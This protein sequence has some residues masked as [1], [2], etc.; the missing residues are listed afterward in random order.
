[1]EPSDQRICQEQLRELVHKSKI[2]NCGDLVGLSI[3]ADVLTNKMPELNYIFDTVNPSFAFVSEILPKNRKRIY[4]HEEFE[5]QG[6]DKIP[7]KT[8][9]EN[10]PTSQ[11]RGSILYIKSTLNYKE[12]ILKPPLRDFEECVAAEITI[13]AKENL[14]CTGIYRR[15]ESSD[16]NNSLL[17]DIINHIGSFKSSHKS[18]MG[19]FNLGEIN[20]NSLTCPG[21]KI[22]DFNHRFIECIRD[23]YFFQHISEYTRQRG[24]D[25]PTTLD[26]LFSNTEDMYENI[27]ICQPLGKSD[28][29]IIKFSIPCTFEKT[30]PIIK[31]Q[32]EKGDYESFKNDLNAIN[33]ESELGKTPDDVNEQWKFFKQKFMELDKKYVPRKLVYIN[34]KL[35]KKFSNSLDKATLKKIKKKNKLW[36]KMRKNLASEEEKLQYN[37][38]R[39]QIRRLTRKLRKIKEKSIA[40]CVKS[41]PKAFWQYS[42]QKLKKRSTIPDLQIPGTDQDPKFATDDEG[43]AELLVDYFSS[44]FTKEPQNDELPFFE[45]R[46]YDTELNDIDITE[47]IVLNKL[48]KLKVNKSPGPDLI[49]PRVLRDVSPAIATPV[50]II[51]RTSLRTKE[52][53]D[54][55]KHANVSAVFKNKGEKTSPV[56]YRPVSLTCILCKVMESIIRDS[57][58]DHMKKN[59]LFSSQQFGFI[60]GRSTVLQLMHVIDIWTQI[61]D[62]GGNIDAVY[63]D[64]MKAFDKVPHNRL[65]YKVHQYGITNFVHGWIKS[66]LNNRTQCVQLGSAKSSLHPVTSGIPQGSVLGPILFVI[67]INDMPE[68]VDK[69]SFVYLFADD[70]KVF[71]KIKNKADEEVLQR[72]VDNLVNWSNIWLLKFHPDKCIFMGIGYRG[73]NIPPKYNMGE[74]VLKVSDCEK[75]IGVH[76]DKDLNFGTHI[77]K[78]INK[79]NRVMWVVRSTYDKLDDKTFNLLFKALVRPHLEYGA[80]VWSPHL[81]KY[82]DLIENVQRRASK[83]VAGLSDL[84]YPNRLRKLNMPTLAY[85]RVRGDMIQTFKLLR[86]NLKEGGYDRSLPD[87]LSTEKESRYESKNKGT[88]HLPILRFKNPLREH[89]F[90]LRIRK[91]WNSLPLQTKMSENIKEFEKS[92]DDHWSNQDLMYNNHKAKI[93]TI[94]SKYSPDEYVV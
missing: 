25:K 53:P 86:E 12:H 11:G 73:E 61:I 18:M 70:T 78:A 71:R 38:I 40:K 5:I 37:S 83:R 56:N 32:Y 60:N 50:T 8:L 1:M 15:G 35:S 14:L 58:I 77:S 88:Y 29:S 76:I 24:S 49:H 72:D 82:N 55:W 63:C 23:N 80:P 65:T 10:T 26:L 7:H 64:F 89:S 93:N 31:A 9:V 33:W 22:D 47:D 90:S 59:N 13:N 87:L 66:F 85:R 54:D 28:H 44:V 16:K 81:Q 41:N 46:I 30:K 68:V 19:D 43:K 4:Y 69:T 21:N 2:Q 45:K 52:L 67:Y 84:D 51:F 36:S 3:N 62:E 48:Q 42:Q 34:G 79:A 91:L 75:D 17:I 57:L 39:N 6:Y 27:E 94:C 20:W 74:H 92:L